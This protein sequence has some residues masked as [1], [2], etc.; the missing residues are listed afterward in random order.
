MKR[1][2]QNLPEGNP[3]GRPKVIDPVVHMPFIAGSLEEA[4]RTLKDIQ[5]ECQNHFGIHFSLS[6]FCRA[7]DEFQSS[8][9][10]VTVLAESG[11]TP[12]NM[13]RRVGYAN[14]FS[15]MFTSRPKTLL[16]MDELG[17]LLSMQHVYVSL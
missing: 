3:C 16:F 6:A 5:R 14:T 9:K 7:L 8:F 13:E 11:E 4:T 17:F 2:Q 12:E 1:H 10:R 15:W